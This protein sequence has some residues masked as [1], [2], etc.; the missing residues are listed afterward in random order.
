MADNMSDKMH[1]DVVDSDR[2][3]LFA[4]D[5]HPDNQGPVRPIPETEAS[6]RA[7]VD[8]DQDE[9][10]IAGAAVAPGAANYAQASPGAM[11]IAPVDGVFDGLTDDAAPEQPRPDDGGVPEGWEPPVVDGDTGN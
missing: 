1:D 10:V 2:D 11:G 3:R 7:D 4:D 8:P 6:E 9:G 5:H